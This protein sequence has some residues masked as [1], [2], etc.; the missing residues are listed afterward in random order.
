ML[1]FDAIN[2]S[3]EIIPNVGKKFNKWLRDAKSVKIACPFIS[4]SSDCE[5]INALK[6]KNVSLIC[7]L[8]SQGCNPFTIEAISKRESYCETEVLYSKNL[9]A[10][11][12]I[13]DDE[14]VVLGSANYSRN[15]MSAGTIE[16]A[17][18]LDAKNGK[19]SKDAVDK[20]LLWFENLRCISNPVEKLSDKDWDRLK[21]LYNIKLNGTFPRKTENIKQSIVNLLK[22]GKNYDEEFAFAFWWTDDPEYDDVKSLLQEEFYGCSLDILTDSLSLGVKKY[23]EIAE[24]ERIFQKKLSNK[25]VIVCELRPR[26]KTIENLDVSIEH[27][28]SVYYRRGNRICS[29]KEADSIGVVFKVVE[30][31][32]WKYC[33][34]SEDRSLSK[35]IDEC[36]EMNKSRWNLLIEKDFGY[37]S[38]SELQD[39]LGYRS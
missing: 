34:D 2:E 21:S 16:A 28:L 9:H 10:K 11:V 1:I 12:Y 27:A 35:L 23:D 7:D 13:F 38:F 26:K 24:Y 22:S 33:L 3:G 25:D 5:I 39:F 17:C 20:S 15:G 8:M 37:V 32:K 18:F 31:D 6:D 4:E 29:P 19:N 14:R 36:V 30:E